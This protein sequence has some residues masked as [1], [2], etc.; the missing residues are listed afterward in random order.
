[1]KKGEQEEMKKDGENQG[2]KEDKDLGYW[3]SGKVGGGRHGE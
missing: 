3:V 1:M 2:W